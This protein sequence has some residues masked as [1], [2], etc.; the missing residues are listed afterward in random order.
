MKLTLL[1]FQNSPKS[2]TTKQTSRTV[3]IEVWDEDQDMEAPKEQPNT[4][5]NSE[6]C[7]GALNTTSHNETTNQLVYKLLQSHQANSKSLDK[8]TLLRCIKQIIMNQ[9][10]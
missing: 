7:T 3:N 2:K 5:R 1:L 6:E 8:E 9:R 4:A 10:Q